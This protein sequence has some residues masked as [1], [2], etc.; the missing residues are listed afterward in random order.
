MAG[1]GAI[2]SSL[3]S[4]IEKMDTTLQNMQSDLDQAVN[5]MATSSTSSTDDDIFSSIESSLGA[6]APSGTSDSSSLLTGTDTVSKLL[7]SLDSSNTS[8][9][10]TNTIA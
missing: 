10:T 6:S 8:G 3:S 7:S 2:G 5:S 1:I 9:T 4:S